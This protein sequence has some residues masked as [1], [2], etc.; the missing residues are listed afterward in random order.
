MKISNNYLACCYLAYGFANGILDIALPEVEYEWL[1]IVRCDLISQPKNNSRHDSFLVT[2]GSYQ[3]TEYFSGRYVTKDSTLEEVAYSCINNPVSFHDMYD[4]L[5]AIKLCITDKSTKISKKALEAEF[6]QEIR[7]V[8]FIYGNPANFT[9]FT[10]GDTGGVL[11]NSAKG[12]RAWI[13]NKNKYE[14]GKIWESLPGNSL[15]YEI[16]DFKEIVKNIT[17]P[18]LLHKVITNACY[19]IC[20]SLDTHTTAEYA[21]TGLQGEDVRYVRPF[22]TSDGNSKHRC[23]FSS[24][25]VAGGLAQF[26]RNK[27]LL[28]KGNKLS[29]LNSVMDYPDYTEISASSIITALRTLA[30]LDINYNVLSEMFDK[31]DTKAMGILSNIKTLPLKMALYTVS[32]F[33]FKHVK[34]NKLS[35]ASKYNSSVISTIDNNGNS[36]WNI[37]TL[38]DFYGQILHNVGKYSLNKIKSESGHLE[39]SFNYVDNSLESFIDFL[40]KDNKFIFTNSVDF[41][42]ITEKVTDINCLS[43]LVEILMQCVTYSVSANK[44][45]NKLLVNYLSQYI[46]IILTDKNVHVKAENVES[47]GGILNE[48]N[49]TVNIVLTKKSHITNENTSH[50]ED[51][52][53]HIPSKVILALLEHCYKHL[54][55]ET[56]VILIRLANEIVSILDSLQRTVTTN[57]S[58]HERNLLIGSI[59][60]SIE[61]AQTELGSRSGQ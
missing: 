44:D 60:N 18:E 16:T 3:I 48:S 29:S 19:A 41:E 11:G 13:A 46:Q 5:Y 10:I 14:Y 12:L 58:T 57:I 51:Y 21:Y 20:T 40:Q 6:N 7:E 52:Y 31:N 56:L 43:S 17:G 24:P 30:N 32:H 23:P 53:R 61:V 15:Y 38:K 36:L 42:Q 8:H 45:L 59:I 34:F 25:I 35:A 4:P 1:V 49:Y 37:E 9:I 27:D 22:C 50:M 47:N 26:I 55:T 39:D 33:P 2:R 54:H 28:V